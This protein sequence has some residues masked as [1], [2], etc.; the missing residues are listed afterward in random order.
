M[1]TSRV[2][3]PVAT[4]TYAALFSDHIT[5][6]FC[7]EEVLQK[8]A[9]V[10]NKLNITCVARMPLIRPPLP[11]LQQLHRLPIEAKQSLLSSVYV[12]MYRVVHGTAALRCI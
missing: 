11:L 12:C 10:C 3:Q 7:R 4:T 8:P 2:Q 6:L 5:T 9:C 1:L